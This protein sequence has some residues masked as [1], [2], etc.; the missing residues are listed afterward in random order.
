M[1]CQE[2][3]LA[4]FF[5]FFDS[6]SGDPKRISYTVSKARPANQGQSPTVFP[7]PSA[8]RRTRLARVFRRPETV[9]WNRTEHNFWAQEEVFWWSFLPWGQRNVIKRL[10]GICA[11][12]EN[13][14]KGLNMTHDSTRLHRTRCRNLK[15]AVAKDHPH[16][17]FADIHSTNLPICSRFTA[18]R[19]N[20]RW[21]RH[22]TASPICTVP[23]VEE[24]RRSKDPVWNWTL[25]LSTKKMDFKTKNH[26]KWITEKKTWWI[27]SLLLNQILKIFCCRLLAFIGRFSSMDLPN[28]PANQG[29]GPCRKI[30]QRRGSAAVR[31]ESMSRASKSTWWLTNEG[32]WNL[33]WFKVSIFFPQVVLVFGWLF[34]RGLKNKNSDP[35]WEDSG[36]HLRS[37]W[38]IG[39]PKS[40]L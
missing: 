33:R 35:S 38:T 13:G 20:A 29:P 19:W 9:F 1:S 7:K 27:S 31:A 30:S 16:A 14:P 5:R 22:S 3:H 39:P 25:N 23:G 18:W 12:E 28:F 6:R 2:D 36:D 37:S 15:I 10:V 34:F 8:K 26:W 11:M 24:F 4:F 17:L 32:L 40:P 21:P